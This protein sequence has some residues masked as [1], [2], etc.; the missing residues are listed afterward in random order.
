MD[1][2]RLKK[3]RVNYCDKGQRLCNEVLKPT[4]LD[5]YDFIIVGAGS[6]GSVVANRLTENKDWKVLLVEAGGNP[7]LESEVIEPFKFQLTASQQDRIVY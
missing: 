4:G 1:R 5:D 3:V 2:R 6:A 7:P